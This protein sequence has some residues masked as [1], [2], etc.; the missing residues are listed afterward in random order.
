M[1]TRYLVALLLIPGCLPAQEAA[2]LFAQRCA[3]CHAEDAS[4]SDRGP[5]LALSRRLRTRSLAE[6]RDT[7]RNGTPGGMPPF[8]LPAGELDALA[9]FIHS[10]NAT[11][12]DA[13]PEGNRAAG[14]RFFFGEG[15]CGS[16]HTAMG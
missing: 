8:K 12:F 1:R 5:A 7:I 14:E 4:G 9:G 10:L 6:I 2:K 3:A 16:C 15:R 11:A 13:Q